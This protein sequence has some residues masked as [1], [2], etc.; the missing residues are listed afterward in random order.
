[1]VKINFEEEL[2]NAKAKIYGNENI[3][4]IKI[5]NIQRFKQYINQVSKQEQIYGEELKIKMHREYNE[6]LYDYLQISGTSI[7]QKQVL[8]LKIIKNNPYIIDKVYEKIKDKD[9]TNVKFDEKL[10]N[11]KGTEEEFEIN[12]IALELQW[13]RE[14][15][16][17]VS[18]QVIEKYKQ[19][20]TEK[21]LNKRRK[22]QEELKKVFKEKTVF[23]YINIFAADTE[24]ERLQRSLKYREKEI[25][26]NMLNNQ[27]KQYK[28][29]GEFLKKYDLLNLYVKLQNTDYEKLE[30]PQMKYSKEQ[31]EKIFDDEYISTLKPIQ[32]ALLNAFWQNRFTKEATDYGEIL[33]IF[34]TLDLWENYNRT[35]LT[36]E[37]ITK[38]LEKEE[39]C[40]S[41]F[42]K[43]KHKMKET[44]QEKTFSYGLI[45]V[46]EIS[47][48]LKEQYKKYFDTIIPESENNLIEDISYGQNRRNVKSVIYKAKYSMIQELLLNIE[49][50]PNITN[51]GY[52]QEKNFGKNTIQRNKKHILI[53]IDYP[54]F[55][56]PLRL[57]IDKEEVLNLIK[58]RKNST[59]IPIYEGNDDFK[60]KGKNLTTKLFVPLTESGESEII[61]LNKEIDATDARYS[62]IKHLGNLVTKKVKSIK[63]IYPTKYI[64]IETGIEGIKTRDNKFMPDN[65]IDNDEKL[66]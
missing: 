29:A 31:I 62:Y 15:S 36:K 7:A 38:V 14:E 44:V 17:F 50:K 8:A 26:K 65:T 42:D 58:I 63:K 47:Q 33:F 59:I 5:K 54:G 11:L 57:H 56:M 18:S 49:H 10:S 46:N 35:E 4:N 22:Y 40:D 53:A 52:V 43:I 3:P 32:L 19:S 12:E 16:K 23:E 25:E 48:E 66:R 20:Q 27:T 64:D 60:Y 45:D 55:N 6:M 24:R 9:L 1:M 37:N 51:W 21:D 30:M 13:I 41:I 28:K 34:D 2:D 39:I 61:K